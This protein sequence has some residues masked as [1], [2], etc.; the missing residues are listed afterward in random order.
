MHTN[1]PRRNYLA[2][3]TGTLSGALLLGALG[4]ALG[5]TY[6]TY[7]MPYA[8]LDA[9]IPPVMG[10]LGGIWL[11]AA[12]GCWIVLHWLGYPAAA[13]TGCFLAAI[14]PF[15]AV[16]AFAVLSFGGARGVRLATP[17]W[18]NTAVGLCL[19]AVLARAWALRSSTS[20]HQK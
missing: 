7:L 19:V 15:A 16:A 2:A 14:F 1:K 12:L 20:S 11:G 5:H 9:L 6:V 3:C 4:V 10:G 13:R 8:E 18:L 17:P